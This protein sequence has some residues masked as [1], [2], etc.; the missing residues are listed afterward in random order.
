MAMGAADVVPGVSGGTIAFITGIYEELLESISAINLK[1]L[2][3]IKDHGFKSAWEKINGNFLLILFVGI[4]I[5]VFSLAR[6]ITYAMDNYPI[7]VWSLFFG[8]VLSSA[9]LIGKAIKKWEYQNI[10][11]FLVGVVIAFGITL[12]SPIDSPS[13]LYY[14][15]FSGAIAICA[16]VLPGISGSFIL[17][18]M[19]SYT[20]VLNALN[21]LDIIIISVFLLGCLFG[22]FS[23]TK[24][25]NQLF[26]KQKHLAIA[27]LTGFLIG[28]LNKI[29]PWKIILETRINS[30]GEAVPFIEQNVMPYNF[31]G[32][33]KV[34][35]A[36][37]IIFAAFGVVYFL[38]SRSTKNRLI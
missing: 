17:L 37:I 9:F 21:E 6:I 25:L 3:F 32:E 34:F 26:K 29:W 23:I 38:D 4:M 22:L 28:S 2:M 24:L 15:F 27:T 11:G 8:L 19:G 1:I 18:L 31:P 12:M 13:S 30:K 16:M 7:F 20:L 36:L 35:M 5:S 14:V 10:L 33:P